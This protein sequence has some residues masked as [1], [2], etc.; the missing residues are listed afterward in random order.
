M[1]KKKISTKTSSRVGASAVSTKEYIQTLVAIKK[2][3]QEAQVKA[4]LAANK[5][6]I[7]LYWFIGKTIVEKQ[8]KSG[9]GSSVIERLANDLQKELPGLGGFSR[10]NVFRMK[11][12]FEAYEKVAQAAR[13]I[14]DIPIFGIPW[15]HN[16]VIMQKIKDAKERLWY[17]EKAIEH[18]WSRTRSDKRNFYDFV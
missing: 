11:A 9:W 1:G 7:K 17:A 4:A 2:Q 16:V 18:G 10:A 14:D 15:F 3:V 8:K 6:L 5:E 13:Q 12:F